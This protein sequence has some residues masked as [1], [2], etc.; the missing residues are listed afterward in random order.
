MGEA[1]TGALPASVATAVTKLQA[2]ARAMI[3]RRKAREARA[4][5]DIMRLL[6]HVPRANCFLATLIGFPSPSFF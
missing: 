2:R 4:A 3:A 5:K 1:L 6:D